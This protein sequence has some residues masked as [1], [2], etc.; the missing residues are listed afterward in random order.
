MKLGKVAAALLPTVRRV[1][2]P[3]RLQ[4]IGGLVDVA[5]LTQVKQWLEECGCT[6]VQPVSVTFYGREIRHGCRYRDK[7]TAAPPGSPRA[8]QVDIPELRYY[9]LGEIPK[10]YKHG[11]VHVTRSVFSLPADAR[12]WYVSCYITSIDPQFKTYHPF[13]ISFCLGCWDHN[14]LGDRVDTHQ[15]KKAERLPAV[16]T[17]VSLAGDEYDSGPAVAT[18]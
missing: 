13:G 3:R 6:E 7:P 4:M 5:L 1:L 8:G 16:I 9:L 14:R 15:H 18:G 12:D 10:K 17:E 2:S 11:S